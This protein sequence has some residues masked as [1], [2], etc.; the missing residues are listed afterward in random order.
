MALQAMGK[1]PMLRRRGTPISRL[2]ASGACPEAPPGALS[3][4]GEDKCTGTAA[5]AGERQSRR[6]VL[7][8]SGRSGHTGHRYHSALACV[9][10]RPRG[11]GLSAGPLRLCLPANPVDARQV[12]HRRSG[13]L[14][15]AEPVQMARLERGL[16]GLCCA[17]GEDRERQIHAGVDAPHGAQR[18][19]GDA[20][21]SHQS[22]RP[23]RAKGE[24]AAGH[25]LRER[26]EPD[27]VQQR[28]VR[29]AI[30]GGDAA[31]GRAAVGGG[32]HDSRHVHPARPLSQR[33][34]G[35]QG[36]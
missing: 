32:D 1:M 2:P 28:H 30:Q 17:E 14:R 5:P 7:S 8:P 16:H 3:S 36:V 25:V 18:P 23:G 35:G 34:R 9:D 31:R 24:S 20:R 4:M 10:W 22:Q 6:Q 27:Q 29:L 11:A 12:R 15:A 26:A 33:G 13:R 19:A 21:R